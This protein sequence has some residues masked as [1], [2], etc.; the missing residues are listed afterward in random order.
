[1]ILYDPTDPQRQV[2]RFTF[3]CQSSKKRLCISNLFRNVDFGEHDVIG[4]TCVTVGSE[5]SQRAKVCFEANQYSECPYLYGMSVECAEAPAELW[6]QG[7]RR[8]GLRIESADVL[9]VRALLTQNYRGSCYS[10]GY[11]ACPNMGDQEKLFRFLEPHR[12]GS[13]LTENW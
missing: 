1:M 9:I 4:F 12:I 6:H 8:G 2:E 13:H 10:F 3:P 7:M 5:A 11:V